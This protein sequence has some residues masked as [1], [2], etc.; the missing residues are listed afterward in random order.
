MSRTNNSPEAGD[1]PRRGLGV[2]GRLPLRVFSNKAAVA[3]L[4]GL[5]TGVVGT[6][7]LLMFIPPETMSDNS[8]AT[9]L[10][11]ALFGVW[12]FAIAIVCLTAFIHDRVE[13][14]QFLASID[15]V[16]L[17]DQQAEI[18]GET[19]LNS[20]FCEMRDRLCQGIGGK[21][22]RKW[23]ARIDSATFPGANLNSVVDQWVRWLLTGR[24]SP[25]LRLQG[26]LKSDTPLP[27]ERRAGHETAAWYAEQV[28]LA[29][30]KADA[31][32]WLDILVN[33][34]GW[35]LLG[36]LGWSIFVWH[37]PIMTIATITLISLAVSTWTLS[38]G[39]HVTSG[40]VWRAMALH[41]I[42]LLHEST[43]HNLQPDCFDYSCQAQQASYD[44]DQ[45]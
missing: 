16:L 29:A 28:G 33:G 17:D 1:T 2:A 15:P 30:Q 24:N 35:G 3:M 42:A 27:G 41:L 45:S 40:S 20:T 25:I 12:V 37:L 22:A 9:V 14:S 44:S 18:R 26:H 5:L 11:A 6:A 43:P 36:V 8:E 38:S 21:D 23:R 13:K 10:M 4:P 7:L 39:L 31:P 19:D 34:L 32:L